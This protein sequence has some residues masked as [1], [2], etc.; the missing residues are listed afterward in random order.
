MSAL[1]LVVAG[2]ITIAGPAATSAGAGKDGVAG[3]D[4]TRAVPA[5]EQP[6]AD[7]GGEGSTN[8]NRVQDGRGTLDTFDPRQKSTSRDVV[9]KQ[10]KQV[11]VVNKARQRSA[12]LGETGGRVQS[13][14]RGLSANERTKALA[15]A[16]QQAKAEAERQIEEERRKAEEEAKRL[17]ELA[18]RGLLSEEELKNLEKE[19]RFTPPPGSCQIP[20]TPGTYSMGSPFGAVGSWAVYHTGQDMPAPYGTPIRAAKAG[21][22][23]PGVGGWAGNDIVIAHAGG[24]STLYAHMSHRAA[25]VGQSV[26]AGQI[27]GYVGSTGRSSG[28]HLHFE[29]YPAGTRPGNVLTA[30]N[31][32]SW[33]RACGA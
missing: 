12:Q 15:E 4:V 3:P 24:E 10:L 9:R 26:Q 33:L 2:S 11:G 16:E 14:N 31:P 22:V 20:L 18:S 23:M 32:M 21:V 17:A 8:P 13:N 29:F 7:T 28:P 6:D 27:I 25:R 1:G 5:A 19:G 30:R